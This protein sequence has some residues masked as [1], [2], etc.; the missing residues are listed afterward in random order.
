MN[1]LEKKWLALLRIAMGWLMFYAGIT[2][3]LDPEWT[4]AGY[5]K[6]AKTFAGMYQWFAASGQIGLIDFVN[7][8][9]LTLLGIS[10]I[11]G[12]GVRLS[13][14]LGAVLMLFYYFPV[15]EFPYAGE[16]SYVVDEHIIYTLVLAFLA[17]VRAGRH[18]G[19]EEWFGKT[20]LRGWPKF[21]R[22]WG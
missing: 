22:I 7:K 9:G 6:S 11:L 2:K 5:A 12:I 4:A 20:F 13:A 15:L 1:K 3:V 16:H 18:F 21:Q 17:A 14:S 10:L 8:W 19:L